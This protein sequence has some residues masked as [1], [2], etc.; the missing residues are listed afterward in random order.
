MRVANEERQG[1]PWLVVGLVALSLILTTVY[2]RE[3]DAG[4]IRALRSGVL[5][6]FAPVS[7]VGDVVAS[8]FAGAARWIGGLGA[9]RTE[10]EQLRTQNGE[11]RAR[12]AEL[13]E[14]ALEGERLRKLVLFAEAHELE[15]KGAHVIGRPVSTW[16]GVIT[17][18]VG[19]GDGVAIGM[20]VIAEE[21]LIGQV[22]DVSEGACRVRLI[23]DQRSG[24][25]AMV[26]R[27]RATG[28]VRGSVEG[29]LTLD[30]VDRKTVPKAGDV[31]LTSG[32]GGVYPKGLLVGEVTEVEMRP[33]DLFPRIA[34]S[35]AVPISRLE[36]VLVIT[37]G[38]PAV[39][40][41]SGE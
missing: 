9:S 23:T 40:G 14:A 10:L 35:S 7:T 37:G 28:I 12:L 34:V 3:G 36:E 31:V 22:V 21:G 29:E 16:E 20:P 27:T 4:P 41:V 6:A 39:E 8:P 15:T 19:A 38:A 1:S 2:Y 13:E 5:A 11:L 24:V 26:Q 25:A 18:D 33:S 30:F 32:L 17:L